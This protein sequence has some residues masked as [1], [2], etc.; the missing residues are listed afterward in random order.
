M[1][2][3]VGYLQLTR[4][5][6]TR[7]GHTAGRAEQGLEVQARGRGGLPT[8][9]RGLVQPPPPRPG[10]ASTSAPWPGSHRAGPGSGATPDQSQ[11]CIPVTGLCFCLLLAQAAS[12]L[13]VRYTS[14][15]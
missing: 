7:P 12:V 8:C 1:D 4:T 6:I 2:S 5:L 3:S 14:A 11:Q 13:D 10:A 9:S 15:S